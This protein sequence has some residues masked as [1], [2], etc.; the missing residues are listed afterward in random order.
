MK[1]EERET[2]LAVSS[3]LLLPI[4]EGDARKKGVTFLCDGENSVPDTI[5]ADIPHLNELL[6][7][8]LGNAV[9]FTP[10]GGTVRY[11]IER[12]PDTES[13]KLHVRFT[14]SDTGIGIRREFLPSI[15]DAFRQD[16]PQE[17]ESGVG[18]GLTIA[19]NLAEMMG[20]TITA[21]SIPGKGSTFKIELPFRR[22]AGA[23]TPVPA[24]A[25]A[26]ALAVLRGKRV[27]L[28]EDN[29]MNREITR[30][31]LE[32]FALTVEEAADG[33]QSV[34]A[35]LSHPVGYYDAVL[36]DIRMPV[37]DGIMAAKEIRRSEHTRGGRLPILA[38]TANAYEEDRK[39]SADA[40]M[41]FHLEKPIDRE[42]LLRRLAESVEASAAG[43]DSVRKE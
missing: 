25:D 9:K 12:L 10:A 19:R 27:L 37:M 28:V 4:I 35:Y 13:E 41:D 16:A 42:L 11:R 21:D 26:R 36:M 2:T 17:L 1:L 8:V 6:L 14:V 34:D 30:D 38:V 22:A 3:E 15:F 23:E 20:G 24:D 18:L 39:A 31:I 5:Y 33:Q 43:A 40:G 32:D 7:C 29:E